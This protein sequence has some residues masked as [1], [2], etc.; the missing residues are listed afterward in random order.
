MEDTS[1]GKGGLVKDEASKRIKVRN[2]IESQIVSKR[3]VRESEPQLQ[4]DVEKLE[5]ELEVF[6]A[7]PDMQH[8]DL[9][10]SRDRY[11]E[12]YELA[13]VSYLTLDR[14]GK[15]REANRSATTLFGVDRAELIGRS[16]SSFMEES[17]ADILYHHLQ[18]V[19][20]NHLKV[21]CEL[22]MRSRSGS[23]GQERTVRIDSTAVPSSGRERDE[24][25]SVLIDY[26]ELR[27]LDTQKKRVEAALS[28]EE[29]RFSAIADV[30]EDVFYT[31]DENHHIL[32]VSPAY[33]KLW[34]EPVNDLLSRRAKWLDGVH[35]DD[36]ER[37]ALAH[38][39]ALRGAPF[40]EEY[41]IVRSDG[42]TCWI[43]DRIIAA[44]E[45][46]EG[47]R[48]YIGIAHDVSESRKLEEELRQAQKIEAVGAL[49]TGVAHDFGNVL[50]A[51]LGCV[52]L[53]RREGLSRE[54]VVDYLDRA[55]SAARRGGKLA[56]QLMTFARKKRVQTEPLEADSL[57]R[58][59]ARLIE[60]LVTEQ[61]RVLVHTDA[62]GAQIMADPVEI[63]Q[64]LMNFAAN[65]KDAM[66]E[67]GNLSICTEIIDAADLAVNHRGLG[68]AHSYVR[69]TVG[70]T[71]TGMDEST[72]R[73]IFE[74]FFTTKEAGRG[75]G[76]GLST[77]FAIVK[78]LSAHIEVQSAPGQGTSFVILFPIC[79]QLSE[80]SRPSV[81]HEVR[82]DG[83]V[84]LVEDEPT[85]RMTLRHKLEELGLEVLEAN[86]PIEAQQLC[87]QHDLELDLLM[88][89]VVLPDML[90][91]R[92][93][94]L[95]QQRYPRLRVLLMSASHGLFSDADSGD[96]DQV[97]LRKPF[98][99][100][101]LC[102][103]LEKLLPSRQV[104]RVSAPPAPSLPT[105]YKKEGNS[106]QSAQQRERPV[107]MVVDDEA[108]ARE[109]LREFLENEGYL[110]LSAATTSE[111]L[112][113]A[114]R[115]Q[116][117]DLVV[118]DILLPHTSG[119]DLGRE[120]RKRHP[121]IKIVLMSAFSERP[122]DDTVFV[123]KP[124]DLEDFARVI[125][126]VL[127]LN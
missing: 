1:S 112:D 113:L 120:L 10:T 78:K 109:N 118:S 99:R 6:R 67:G 58:K 116:R 103:Q 76:L 25:R 17:Q 20:E 115:Q 96:E 46:G 55:A 34:G 42:K 12:L 102:E 52:N 56:D 62:R 11:F 45:Q 121:R 123:Q 22:T 74:P 21:T 70:D 48:H 98:G 127:H 9:Q 33:E 101:E 106:G 47:S 16:F 64:I 71:G 26:S 90:G 88:S 110:T 84:L 37:I 18:A 43:Q 57:I 69:L 30:S 61:V 119:N 122:S 54:R 85:V 5:H 114:E 3:C 13:P 72:K 89:D 126:E 111:A 15:I 82:F 108:T 86:G 107:V 24:C 95:L 50:Q 28:E 66:P 23:V 77:V 19:F 63:E 97:L 41:R 14:S 92:L 2:R 39:R 32:Y 38:S 87:A 124:L 65:A 105:E 60:C 8:E 81:H 79:K 27:A 36:R 44:H 100:A 75:T 49:A 35:P 94:A 80:S 117:I 7:E 91:T 40:D 73:R 104:E 93:A 68:Q 59:S 51:V 4:P 125:A 53:A 29:A 83:T 31:M